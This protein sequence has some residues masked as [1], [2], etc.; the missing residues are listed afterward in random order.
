MHLKKLIKAL[1]YQLMIVIMCGTLASTFV[2]HVYHNDT[3]NNIES[4]FT[5]VEEVITLKCTNYKLVKNPA[6]IV[7]F[8][9]KQ[10]DLNVITDVLFPYRLNQNFYNTS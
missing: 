5:V 2:K 10:L 1:L 9:P 3:V 6:Q 8:E 4:V 7:H